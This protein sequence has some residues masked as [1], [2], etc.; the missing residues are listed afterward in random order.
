MQNVKRLAKP[1]VLERN[2]KNWTKTLLDQIELSKTTGVPVK[3]TFYNKYNKKE[4]RD[5]LNKMYQNRCCYCESKIGIVDFPHIEHRKPKRAK[6]GIPPVPYPESTYDWDNLHLACQKCNNAKGTQYDIISPI[7]D[8]VI[9]I[10]I[11]SH[12][13]Y[14]LGVDGLLWTPKTRRGTTTMEHADLNR[15]E[16]ASARLA[17]F[18]EVYNQLIMIND[19]PDNPR[20]EI[21]L[22]ELRKRAIG[23]NSYGSIISFILRNQGVLR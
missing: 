10:P 9:D 11:E 4:I 13:T 22:S 7:L 2:V 14:Y 5:T 21:V 19:M 20:N 17:V 23:K 18:N 1:K 12:F 15:T 3:D 16:L 6:N 8:S